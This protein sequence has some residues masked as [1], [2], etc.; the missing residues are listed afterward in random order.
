M[1]EER[2][3]SQNRLK[4]KA[5]FVHLAIKKGY[6]LS[7]THT[8]KDEVGTADIAVDPTNYVISCLYEIPDNMLKELDRV[9]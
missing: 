8:N 7:F 9:E 1:D 2:I 4:G 6:K 5:K 3:N